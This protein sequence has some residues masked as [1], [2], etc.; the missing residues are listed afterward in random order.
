MPTPG[1]ECPE[2]DYERGLDLTSG[3]AW[4]TRQWTGTRV[5]QRTLISR[6]ANALLH[7]VT[8]TG[9]VDLGIR[10]DTSLLVNDLQTEWD[11]GIGVLTIRA[12]LPWDVDPRQPDQGAAV[13]DESPLRW[14]PPGSELTREVL[15]CVLLS[16]DGDVD[17]RPDR[18]QVCAATWAELVLTCEV[19]GSPH[20]RRA[21]PAREV[22][23]ER[24]A[25]AA[26]L[27]GRRAIDRGPSALVAE[28]RAA[29]KSSGSQEP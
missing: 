6:P 1:T 24:A 29:L 8:G 20:D 19:T 11:V 27:R 14:G 28:H 13:L 22:R 17:V 9:P 25:R 2:Q 12:E 4:V 23:G 3:T 26:R 21:L 10:L 18:L 15:L 7:S 5:R 16:T